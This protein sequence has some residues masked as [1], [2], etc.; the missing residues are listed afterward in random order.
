MPK[1]NN[2]PARTPECHPERKHLARGLCKQCYDRAQGAATRERRNAAARRWAAA[3]KDKRLANFRKS[4][5]GI[6][7]DRVA[8][9]F[10]AQDGLCKIC[11]AGP[12]EHLD[13]DHKTGAARGLLCGPCNRALGMFRDDPVRLQRAIDYLALWEGFN[14]LLFKSNTGELVG[15]STRGLA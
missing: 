14:A 11:I 13:H 3:N 12:A 7:A 6:D 15:Q 10:K 1:K 5:Y 4:R 9:R 2:A 8:A